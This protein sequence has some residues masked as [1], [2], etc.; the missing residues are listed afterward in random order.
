MHFVG[1]AVRNKITTAF[2]L[3]LRELDKKIGCLCVNETFKNDIETLD[4]IEKN[5][6]YSKNIELKYEKQMELILNNMKLIRFAGVTWNIN[7]DNRGLETI[8]SKFAPI[9]P[10]LHRYR[11]MKYFLVG[12][13]NLGKFPQNVEES[14]F[15]SV[16]QQD[17]QELE[18]QLKET[19]DQ[20]FE[21]SSIISNQKLEIKFLQMDLDDL[22]IRLKRTKEEL[23][24]QY[25]KSIDDA[26]RL[27]AAETEVKILTKHNKE[28][29]SQIGKLGKD[30]NELNMTIL[31]LE[32][33]EEE[34]ES[35]KHALKRNIIDLEARIR[36]LRNDKNELRDD[37]YQLEMRI[38]KLEMDNK[39]L[40]KYANQSYNQYEKRKCDN[41]RKF[42]LTFVTILSMLTMLLIPVFV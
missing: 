38:T 18:Q 12:N 2:L 19:R 3:T 36:R 25:K 16:S 37:K 24:E 34:L 42:T 10:F 11:Q 26:G 20:L 14:V 22:K 32:Q 31:E 40:Q 8:Y 29:H 23:D 41:E 28:L 35:G 39:R 4:Q 13:I 27:G 6:K 5:E 7:A 9:L 30:I 15:T 33:N 21:K 1:C 17:N